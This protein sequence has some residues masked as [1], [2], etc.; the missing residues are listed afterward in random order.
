MN[1]TNVT[2]SG[3]NTIDKLSII[4]PYYI[5]SSD[6]ILKLEEN[7]P[8][9]VQDV[10]PSLVTS[11][12]FV[13]ISTTIV[14]VGSYSTLARP[15]N[16]KDAIYDKESV[17]FDISDRDDDKHLVKNSIYL[18]GLF[19]GSEL[20]WYH[21]FSLPVIASLALY[22]L[23]YLIKNLTPELL[24]KL[25]NWYV[26]L[27]SGPVAYT[28]YHFFTT[29]AARKLGHYFKLKGNS[30]WFFPRYRLCLSL[31]DSNYP[32]GIVD[33]I[34]CEKLLGYNDKQWF[35][36]F[37]HY[38]KNE[39]NISVLKPN[40]IKSKNQT[41]NLIF[42]SKFL[43]LLPISLAHVGGY[44]YLSFLQDSP[45]NWLITNVYGINFAIFGI[46]NLKLPNFT[47]AVILLVGLF[48]YDIYFVFGTTIM[49]TVATTI[50][51]P[52][53]ILIPT[54]PLQVGE[55]FLAKLASNEFSFD[56][57]PTSLLGL[58]DIVL[59]GAF[60][61]LCL[62][63]DLFK[64][65][66]ANVDQSFHHLQTFPKKY[67]ITS[68]VSYVIGL[69]LTAGILFVFQTGQPALLYI[70]PS[71]LVGTGAQVWYQGDWNELYNFNE[72]LK[73]YDKKPKTLAEIKGEDSGDHKEEAEEEDGDYE[74]S[75]IDESYDEWETRVE[76]ERSEYDCDN[77]E[78]QIARLLQQRNLPP[79]VIYEFGNDS[80][81][82]DDTFIIDEETDIDEEE[83][84]IDNS[85][86]I[87]EID[88][89]VRDSK[90]QPTP[91]YPEEDEY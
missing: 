80:L 66:Q 37:K 28:N 4:I 73:Y 57:V 6:F 22:G 39:N 2:F 34:S 31:D 51:I 42:D 10:Y 20:R 91:W 76:I 8:H 19:E 45:V 49:M 65:H 75:E 50:S 85:D 81:D 61:S 79:P 77:N 33:S 30:A 52:I 58:G 18:Q 3:L 15:R 25:L 24:Q 68:V 86:L 5:Y 40:K 41:L 82:E 27:I 89:L 74:G 71:L 56:R 17:N 67:F 87:D 48:V 21:A 36:D 72:E 43:L 88:I 14:L 64:Y 44:Y 54:R 46:K 78:Q 55:N 29:F 11:F 32:Q 16:A 90:R 35:K 47:F 23:N 84:D 62:R 12:L 59:P 7:H 1:S 13:F 63:Y 9:F 69:T 26:L 60:I 70:V 53:K 83:E 38:L